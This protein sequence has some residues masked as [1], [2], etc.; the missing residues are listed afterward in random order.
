MDT[1]SL[2]SVTSLSRQAIIPPTLVETHEDGALRP[3]PDDFMHVLSSEM[4]DLLEGLTTR[5]MET[6]QLI[7]R[8][9]LNKEIAYELGVTLSTAKAHVSEVICKLKARSRTA[10]AV[11][12]AIYIE[13]QKSTTQE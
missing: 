1:H 11:S 10:A 2:G 7:S 8:G 9:L 13:R 5:Q 12:Y 4:D 3:N 6:L